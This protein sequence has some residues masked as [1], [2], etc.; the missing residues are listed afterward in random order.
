M[1]HGNKKHDVPVKIIKRCYQHA[2]LIP[3]GPLNPK[4]DLQKCAGLS[5]IQK[6]ENQKTKKNKKTLQYSWRE[7]RKHT[8]K[9]KTPGGNNKCKKPKK[10]KE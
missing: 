4:L 7:R 2:T 10:K 9:Q 1:Q 3:K 6:R 8:K 5:T